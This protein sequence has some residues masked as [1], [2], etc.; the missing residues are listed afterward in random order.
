M[1]IL[2]AAFLGLVFTPGRAAGEALAVA[3]APVGCLLAERYCS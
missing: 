1:R 2:F 3:H